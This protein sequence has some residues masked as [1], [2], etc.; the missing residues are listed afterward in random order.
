MNKMREAL[1]FDDVL[2]EPQYSTVASRNDVDLSVSLSKGLKFKVP[3][4][5]ANMKTV[6]NEKVALEMIRL[7]GLSLLH[8]FMPIEEQH[9]FLS[10]IGWPTDNE[11]CQALYAD[12][13]S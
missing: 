7:G 10:Y 1:T 8:R 12:R 6:V 9:K 5:P 2:I 13:P 11:K 4:I 3:V